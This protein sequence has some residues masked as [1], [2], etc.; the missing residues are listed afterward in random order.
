MGLEKKTIHRRLA[1][2][3]T[4]KEGCVRSDAEFKQDFPAAA[5][6]GF[7]SRGKHANNRKK[8]AAIEAERYCATSPR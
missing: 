8:R 2:T 1:Q 4:R 3:D 7:V 5:E 6:A